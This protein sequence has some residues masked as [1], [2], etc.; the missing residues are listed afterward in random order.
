ME[1][2]P[3]PLAGLS[4]AEPRASLPRPTRSAAARAA[5]QPRP[6][7][8]ALAPAHR[9]LARAAACA[10]CPTA[11]A[12]CAPIPAQPR[13]AQ[14]AAPARACPTTATPRSAHPVARPAARRPRA[15]ATVPA[16]R[17]PSRVSPPRVPRRRGR[18]S[19]GNRCHDL[20]QVVEI[21]P[22]AT[23][24]GSFTPLAFSHNHAQR[25]RHTK[26]RRRASP[27]ARSKL[28]PRFFL[29]GF[30]AWCEVLSSPEVSPDP[31]FV[32]SW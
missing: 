7:P 5:Q 10:V 12:P 28:H 16:Q 3:Q 31:P 8:R 9:G 15:Q 11:C 13:A 6:P 19:I 1:S 23:P 17:A 21:N 32:H 25:P 18:A 4:A 22:S 14:R 20:A 27:S 29:V 24:C 2:L 26:R 30:V